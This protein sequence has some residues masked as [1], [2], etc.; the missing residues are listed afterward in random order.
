MAEE[1][2][3]PAAVPIPPQVAANWKTDESFSSYVLRLEMAILV[4][5]VRLLVRTLPPFHDDVMQG[6]RKSLSAALQLNDWPLAEAATRHLLADLRARPTFAHASGEA[7]CAAL[8]SSGLLPAGAAGDEVARAAAA[9]IL[10]LYT[11]QLVPMADIYVAWAH[12]VELAAAAATPGFGQ[13][14]A[15]GERPR[16]ASLPHVDLPAEMLAARESAA[17]AFHYDGGK[18]GPLGV[19]LGKVSTRDLR[20]TAAALYRTA[21]RG[22]A[23]A[24]GPDAPYGLK[25]RAAAERATR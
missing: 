21:A 7:A 24:F 17:A 5:S 20:A 9:P 16:G 18:S 13:S 22:I 6:V 8:E 1:G 12:E 19:G 2:A 4:H 25:Q 14:A 10:P 15:A 23:L 11:L 3:V